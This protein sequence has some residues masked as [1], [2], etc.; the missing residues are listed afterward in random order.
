MIIETDGDSFEEMRSLEQNLSFNAATKEFEHRNTK[1]EAQ[2][3]QTLKIID[4]NGIYTNLGLLLSDQCSHTIKVA[5]FQGVD[6]SEYWNR[7]NF[8]IAYGF[9]TQVKHRIQAL[10]KSPERTFEGA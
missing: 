10:S 4:A 5:F 2:Q 9:E 3:M 7:L 6:Q 8:L 1:F